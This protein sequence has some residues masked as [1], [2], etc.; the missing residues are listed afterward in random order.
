MTTRIKLGSINL[1]NKANR[2][3]SEYLIECSNQWALTFAYTMTGSQTLAERIVADAIVAIISELVASVRDE[4]KN[5]QNPILPNPKLTE[6]ATRLAHYIWEFSKRKAVQ[7]LNEE[8]FFRLLPI[9]RAVCILKTKAKFTRAQ[10]SEAINIEPELVEHQLT[11]GRLLFS[12]GSAW[13]E[14][15]ADTLE[16]DQKECPY[17]NSSTLRKVMSS[18]DADI[19]TLFSQYIG[20]DL[21]EVT[22]SAMHSHFTICTVCRK[23]LVKFKEINQEWQSKIPTHQLSATTRQQYQKYIKQM[24]YYSDDPPPSFLSGVKKVFED[25]KSRLFFTALLLMYLILKYNS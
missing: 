13:I 15:S 6:L 4:L 1:E 5:S 24:N 12:N 20:G 23:N 11:N 3:Q 22:S 18:E 25:P 10:I 19:Q 2:K 14:K 21:D 16:G 9:T 8:G 7:N 17:W